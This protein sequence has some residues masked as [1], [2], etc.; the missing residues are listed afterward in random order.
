MI[1]FFESLQSTPALLIKTYKKVFK[2]MMNITVILN[3]LLWDK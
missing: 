2:Q 1:Y 3:D